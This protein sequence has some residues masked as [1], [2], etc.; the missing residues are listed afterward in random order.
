MP[1]QSFGD[2]E[3][4]KASRELRL[5]I[6]REVVPVLPREERYRLGG[7]VLEAARSVTANI[8]EGY[9]RFHYLDN[10][11]LFECARFVHRSLGPLYYRPRRGDD[12]RPPLG[13]WTRQNRIRSEASQRLHGLPKARWLE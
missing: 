7:Q 3:C 12:Q 11:V 9:G 5:F 6:A 1:I 13:H 4:W 8:A 10:S 2:L